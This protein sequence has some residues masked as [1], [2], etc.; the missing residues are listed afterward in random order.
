MFSINGQARFFLKD[1][2]RS[3]EERIKDLKQQMLEIF[4]QVFNR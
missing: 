2:T 1:D 4:H 3:F